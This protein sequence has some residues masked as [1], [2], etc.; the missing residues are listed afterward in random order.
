MTDLQKHPDYWLFHSMKKRCSCETAT[1]YH[2]YGGRGITVC[3]RWLLPRGQGFRNFIQDMGPR[4]PGMTLERSN[5]NLGYSPENCVWA[6]RKTQSNNRRNNVRITYNGITKT[7]TEWAH[8]L[9]LRGGDVILKRIKNGIPLGEALTIPRL[10]REMQQA[11]INAAALLR[12]S[13]TH[14]KRGHPLSGDNLY[15]YKG[16]RTC[17]TCKKLKKRYRS[18]DKSVPFEQ[19]IQNQS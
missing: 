8:S 9:G 13:R 19:F 14:C 1:A 2:S 12:K 16:G 11:A 4:P 3:D 17:L 7:A 18:S 15:E 6:T 5:T 10:P